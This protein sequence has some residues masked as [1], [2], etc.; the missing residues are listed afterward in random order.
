MFARYGISLDSMTTLEEFQRQMRTVNELEAQRTEH[1][2][3]Q[4]LRDPQV[5]EDNK[6]FI[7]NMLGLPEPVKVVRPT[8]DVIDMA[9][10]RASRSPAS[11]AL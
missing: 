10:W 3:E 5:S 11:T 8:A 1:E 2:L 4:S 9:T 6:A 7:R